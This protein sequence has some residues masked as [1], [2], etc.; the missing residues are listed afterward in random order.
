MPP[1]KVKKPKVPAKAQLDQVYLLTRYYRAI[2]LNADEL[3][4]LL[5]IFYHQV[6]HPGKMLTIKSIADQVGKVERS[7]QKYLTRLS[8]SGALTVTSNMSEHGR[9]PNTYDLAPLFT[10]IAGVQHG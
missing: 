9:L 2:G 5:A 8:A 1:V 7:I 10:A 4:I 3:E 6:E